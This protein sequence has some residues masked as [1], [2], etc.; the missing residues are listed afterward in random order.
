MDG[1]KALGNEIERTL[2]DLLR[3]G[4]ASKRKKRGTDMAWKPIDGKNLTK[5]VTFSRW[6]SDTPR[7]FG[8]F[9]MS[10]SPNAVRRPEA[11]CIS[12]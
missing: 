8:V 9:R 1:S 6:P 2:A 5:F 11:R 7:G 3:A 10:A 4:K 12:V